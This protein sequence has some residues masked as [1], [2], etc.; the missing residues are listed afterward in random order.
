MPWPEWGDTAIT[1]LQVGDALRAA[2]C[3]CGCGQWADL[4]HDPETSGWW[5]V[6][7][8]ECYARAALT[9]WR[10]QNKDAGPETLLGVRLNADYWTESQPDLSPPG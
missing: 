9:E 8:V 10:E 6:E 4:A 1:L 2:R 7:P 5:D 3:P